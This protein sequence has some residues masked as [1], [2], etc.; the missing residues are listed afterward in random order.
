MIRTLAVKLLCLVGLVTLSG[1]AIGATAVSF[2]GSCPAGTQCVFN[3]AAENK[4]VTARCS[5]GTITVN[6]SV[7]GANGKTRSC[8]A[9]TTTACNGK[10]SCTVT[11]SNA[12]CGG[13]PIYGIVKSGSLTLTCSGTVAAPTIAFGTSCASG[14]TCTYA[15]AKESTASLARCSAGTLTV[16]SSLYGIGQK[17]ISCDSYVKA[18]C[19]GKTSC[20]PSFSPKNCGRDPAV[21]IVK[22]GTLTV[23]CS[24]VTAP[25]PTPTPKPTPAATPTPTPTPKPTPAATPAPPTIGKGIPTGPIRAP[26]SAIDMATA[27]FVSPSGLDTNPGTQAKPWKTLQ[28]AVSQIMPGQTLVVR[29][30]RYPESVVFPRS[31]TVSQPIRVVAYPGETPL[32]DGADEITGWVKCSSSAACGGVVDY[33]NT[34]YAPYTRSAIDGHLVDGDKPLFRAQWPEQPHPF[35]KEE[36]KYFWKPAVASGTK[37]SIVDPVNLPTIANLNGAYVYTWTLDNRI[38]T[39]KINAFNRTTGKIDFDIISNIRATEEYSLFNHISFLKKPGHYVIDETAKR[40]Y[41]IPNGTPQQI[42]ISVRKLALNVNGQSNITIDGFKIVGY[43]GTLLNE[44]LAVL[45]L[46]GKP[47]VNL[48]VLNL[49]IIGNRAETNYATVTVGDCNDCT[50][51]GNRIE[52]NGNR[53]FQIGRGSRASIRGNFITM[54][55]GSGM[56]LGGLL[57]SLIDKNTIVNNNGIHANGI[58]VYEFSHRNKVIGNYFVNAQ[59]GVAVQASDNTLIER[60]FFSGADSR[61]LTNYG[62]TGDRTADYT[63][64]R[65]N[66]LLNSYKHA[67]LFNGAGNIGFV[68][69]NNV[70]DGLGVDP[71]ST[72]A[73]T[74]N[75]YV[76]LAWTQDGKPLGPNEYLYTGT[77]QD[78]FV[79]YANGDFRIKAGSK[80]SGVDICK[81]GT[82]G[83]AV[84]AFGC[85]P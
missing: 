61:M 27:L 64:V 50:Y 66:T 6:N 16:K 68:A 70:L 22:T 53:G 82:G 79:D 25:T 76:G 40:I 80:A 45:N 60:N 65:Y 85:A 18:L 62:G 69:E 28:H 33:A 38:A 74:N 56:F 32:L 24:A 72:T 54:N 37:I 57:D 13:D 49:H 4:P 8:A 48:K 36:I 7:Y 43:S 41:V 63:T 2:G 14:K 75:A 3:P 46:I 78:L 9:H 30:G 52:Y 44:G 19:N 15:G 51:E 35:Y 71:A 59:Y 23:A 39:R 42:R 58:A 26:A 21:G 84:G 77:V 5:S 81:L 11:F 10:A 47:I 55:Y 31:G 83:T 17:T 34:Y 73:T 67:A 1:P 20:S 12:N 29:G